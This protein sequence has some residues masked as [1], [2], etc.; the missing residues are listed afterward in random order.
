MKPVRLFALLFGVFFA[1]GA[2]A[3]PPRPRVGVI[4]G[5]PLFPWWQAP[6]PWY[7]PPPPVIVT[8]PPPPP[9]YTE[10]SVPEPSQESADYWYYCP[11][12]GAYYPAVRTCSVAWQAVYPRSAP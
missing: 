3:H 9:V 5:A 10:Q 6:P 7:Y 2:W 8:Q 12:S 4:I 1:L 11:T